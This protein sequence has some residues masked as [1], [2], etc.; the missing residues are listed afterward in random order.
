MSGPNPTRSAS[1]LTIVL[2]PTRASRLSEPWQYD[3]S[4]C[5]SNDPEW[6]CLRMMARSPPALYQPGLLDTLAAECVK[7]TFFLV[8]AQMALGYPPRGCGVTYNEGQTFW[9]AQP[10]SPPS[11]FANMSVDDAAKRFRGRLCVPCRT[12]PVTQGGFLRPSSAF[13]GFACGKDAWRISSP[14]QNHYATWIPRIFLCP[15]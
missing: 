14:R 15:E 10:E 2:D 7:A 6:F 12:V 3:E 4:F 11:T 1:A 9:P 8:D 5:R 13:P